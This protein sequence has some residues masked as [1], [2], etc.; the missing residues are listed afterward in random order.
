MFT[1][2]CCKCDFEICEAEE[3]VETAQCFACYYDTHEEEEEV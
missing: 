2:K 1:V 3:L